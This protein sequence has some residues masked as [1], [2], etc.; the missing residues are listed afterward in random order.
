MELPTAVSGQ[1]FL[2]VHIDLL[3]GRVWLVQ[4]FKTVAAVVA[5]RNFVGSAFRDVGLPDTIVSDRDARFTSSLWTALHAA[6]SASLI[7][8][9][10]HRHNTTSKAKRVHG[11]I[12]DVLCASAGNSSDNRP[13]LVPLVKFATND[14]ASTL[15]SGHTPLYA[16]RGQHPHRP[17]SPSNQ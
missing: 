12:A 2:Q 11:V 17:L 10:Q 9:S 13:E 6:L 15:G 8:G 7:F 1:D 16:D 14:S 4:T 3:T 5:A